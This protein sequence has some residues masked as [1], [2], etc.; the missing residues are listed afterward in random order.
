[1][2]FKRLLVD[3][4]G[5]PFGGR[6]PE[7]SGSGA[8]PMEPRSGSAPRLDSARRQPCACRGQG[9]TALLQSFDLEPTELLTLAEAGAMRSEQ[10]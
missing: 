10:W 4:Y 2:R 5:G 3:R 9:P 7:P 6:R 8:W 1:M